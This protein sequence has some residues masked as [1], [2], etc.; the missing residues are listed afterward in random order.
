MRLVLWHYLNPGIYL[1]SLPSN[2]STQ[3]KASACD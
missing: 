2:G 3:A 1:Q